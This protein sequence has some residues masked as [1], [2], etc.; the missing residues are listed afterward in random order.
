MTTLNAIQTCCGS[1]VTR[2]CDLCNTDWHIETPYPLEEL[3]LRIDRYSA[4][5]LVQNAFQELTAGEREMFM[6]GYC[7]S[8]WDE[9]FKE[10]EEYE[11]QDM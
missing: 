8:C 1:R 4:G 10:E 2:K 9:I 5:E 6:T 11:V 7:T 3:Q